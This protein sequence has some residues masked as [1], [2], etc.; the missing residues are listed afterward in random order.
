MK[1]ELPDGLFEKIIGNSWQF[2]PENIAQEGSEI[3]REEESL[4]SSRLSVR[5]EESSD[6]AP[7]KSS[8]SSS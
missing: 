6:G 4:T 3:P 2:S 8:K 7:S 1:N 5:I